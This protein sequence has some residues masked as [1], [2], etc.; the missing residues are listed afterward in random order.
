VTAIKKILGA[1]T[2]FDE[3]SRFNIILVD[4]GIPTFV[5]D[6]KDGTVMGE[7]TI[8][9]VAPDCEQEPLYRLWHIIYSINDVA[10]CTIALM[11]QF[12]F[13]AE[14]AGRLAM[15]DFVRL[16]FGNKSA[17]AIRKT[18][19]YLMEGHVY[20]DAAAFAGYNH[21]GSVTKDER[22]KK[23]LDDVLQLLPKNSLRQPVVEK[24]LNQ[25]INVVNAIIQQYGRPD[26]IR[27]ELAR[28]LKQS[29]EERNETYRSINK[30]EAENKK[31]AERIENEYRQLGVRATRNTIIK[32]RLFHEINND[33][34]KI[35]ATCIYCGKQFGLTDALKG[36]S[37][38]V[39]HVIPKAK[40]FDDSQQN[41]ILAHRKCN[42]DKKDATAYDF[43]CGKG[44]KE[45][46]AYVE[47]VNWL[48]ENRCIGKGKRDKLLMPAEKIPKNFIDRQL[49]ETQYISRK[50]VEILSKVCN[51]VWVTSG[52]VTERL[53]RLW[54]WDDV[55]MNLQ[56]PKYKKLEGLTEIKEWETNDGQKHQ[57]EVITGWTKRDDHRHHAIDALVIACTRQGFIQRIN[58]LHAQQNRDE[59]KAEVDRLGAAAR[60]GLTLLDRYLIMQ[61]PFTTGQVENEAAKILVSFKPGKR[62]ATKGVRKVKVDGQKE[63]VQR[64]IV[65]P[66][67]PLSEASVYGKIKTIDKNK[68]VKYLLENPH[69]ILKPYIKQ[70]VEQHLQQ[71]NGDVK[72]ALI[73]LKKEP[74]YLDD[75]KTI[76]LTYGSCYKEEVVIKYPIETITAKD[77]AYIV[78]DRV[79]LV[80]QNRLDEYGG[81]EKEAF[82]TP[83][84]YDEQRQIPIRTVRCFTGLSA[85]EPVKRDAQGRD[86]GFV[87]PG[88]NH[89]IAI[90]TDEQGKPTEHVCTFWHAVER[91]KYGIPAVIENP[92]AVWDRILAAKEAYTEPFLQKLP[93]PSWQLKMT[94]QQNEMF[95]LGLS[96]EEL[97][98]AMTTN[99]RKKISDHL[100][101]V[102]S[103]SESDFWFRHHLETQLV[104]D[105]MAKDAQRFYRVKSLGALAKLSP[106]KVIIS[107][108]GNITKV[109]K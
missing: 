7:N 93:E 34:S 37:V 10:E 53:R 99:D 83:V 80:I 61:R 71:H 78:D 25:L 18:L 33:E 91:V 32:W 107:A 56:L 31:I 105:S 87:K 12:G 57:I 30:K 92:A 19:P 69:L 106:E 15:I 104:S 45:L 63:I 95:V 60:N 90:Y 74:L 86:I 54:G 77:V 26:E 102:Q 28:E 108:L 51:N 43:M 22:A 94:M 98:T 13:S 23:V 5:V 59:M 29:R 73:A 88:S 65:V 27:I 44:E 4:A 96:A 11:K 64:G 52:S 81:K 1:G 103:I 49:R 16:G 41:K 40:L 8:K 82:K 68:P 36:S 76:P 70:L 21:S 39:E 100:Y 3:V 50:S 67:G 6:R 66:R 109:I 35:N 14:T 101:R 85:V 38:D 62:V 2:K 24:I 58:R 75:D 46:Q 89:H 55:L 42:E 84:W 48:Y 9:C 72:K 47:R 97:E 20:S 17:K 79:R